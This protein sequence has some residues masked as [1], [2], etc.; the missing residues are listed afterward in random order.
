[1]LFS[2]HHWGLLEQR[3]V[4]VGQVDCV[5]FLFR[6]GKKRG[7]VVDWFSEVFRRHGSVG[8]FSFAQHDA[9]LFELHLLLKLLGVWLDNVL[10]QG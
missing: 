7:L 1:M 5:L 4:S 9:L 8:Y 6:N 3:G 2:S 10:G